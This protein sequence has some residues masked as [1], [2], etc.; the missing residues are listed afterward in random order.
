MFLIMPPQVVEYAPAV[1]PYK[2]LNTQSV[3]KDV[4]KPRARNMTRLAVRLMNA[5]MI[6]ISCLSTR[7]PM[8]THPITQARLTSSKVRVLPSKSATNA[9]GRCRTVSG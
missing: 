2:T 1:K 9:L 3:A 6:V 5:R 7:S 8:P 4:E